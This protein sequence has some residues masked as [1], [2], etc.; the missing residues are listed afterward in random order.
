MT[1]TTSAH[2]GSAGAGPEGQVPAAHG[3]PAADPATDRSGRRRRR[4]GS[5]RPSALAAVGQ[6]GFGAGQFLVALGILAVYIGSM[7]LM[8]EH[9]GD[10]DLQWDREIYL[11]TGFEAIVFVAAG[12]IFGTRIQRASVD[13]AQEETRQA[14]EDLG[15]ERQR[16]DRARQLE[17]ATATFIMALKAYGDS[18]PPGT[19][20]NEYAADSSPDLVGPR[21]RNRAGTPATSSGEMGYAIK[22]A[23]QL[24]SPGRR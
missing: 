11:F 9:S 2:N 4:T 21:G 15:A 16:A 8:F 10:S 17:E 19:E 12:A 22:L 5:D 20:E 7:W 1:G 3:D 24:F 6:R 18:L 14:R 13:A 23:E